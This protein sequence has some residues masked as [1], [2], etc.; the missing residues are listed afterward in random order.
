MQKGFYLDLTR[1]TSCYAC[2]VACKASHALSD[3]KV[4]LRRV[5]PLENGRYPNV[6]V[7]NISLSCLHC[8]TPSCRDICPTKAIHKRTEDGLVIVTKERCIGCKMCLTACPFGI[9][10]FGKDGKMHKCDYCMDRV[11]NKFTPA[12]VNVCPARALHAGPLDELSL[13]AAKKSAR[14]LNQTTVPSLFL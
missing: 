3:D 6:R 1:C 5:F 7:T 12:C 10:E 9:P 2:I 8:A 13:L 4:N 14:R 11:G